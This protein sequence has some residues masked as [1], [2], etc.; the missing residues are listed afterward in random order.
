MPFLLLTPRGSRWFD[1]SG[2]RFLIICLG[3]CPPCPRRGCALTLTLGSITGI[4]WFVFLL[5][6]GVFLVYGGSRARWNLRLLRQRPV[7]C[8]S[9]R[10]NGDIV[11]LL[12]RLDTFPSGR[13]LG[14][15]GGIGL[16]LVKDGC[17]SGSPPGGCPQTWLLSRSSGLG[18]F[19]GCGCSSPTSHPGGRWTRR[20]IWR[21]A[22]STHNFTSRGIGGL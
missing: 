11:L 18:F 22:G 13:F 19:R 5:S 10:W 17:V 15:W 21:P 1:G 7:V 20:D 6:R 4:A 8:G 9:L 12:N 2:F 14:S 16:T 3:R